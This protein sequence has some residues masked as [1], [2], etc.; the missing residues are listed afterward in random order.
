[1]SG[2]LCPRCPAR[3]QAL[4][5]A[6]GLLESG[7]PGGGSPFSE[8]LALL[9]PPC[10]G[11]AVWDLCPNRGSTEFTDASVTSDVFSNRRL[12]KIIV[13]N[14]RISEASSN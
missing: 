10:L 11:A 1:M 8:A 9:L 7:C 3:H 5:P 2:G 14:N 13:Y 4:S 12:R 6:C